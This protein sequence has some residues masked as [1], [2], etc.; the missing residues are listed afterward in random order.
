MFPPLKDKIRIFEENCKKKELNKG[1]KSMFVGKQE[2]DK[3]FQ[4]LRKTQL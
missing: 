4:S 3:V 2:L 1:N